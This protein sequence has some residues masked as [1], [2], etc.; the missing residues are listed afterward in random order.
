[1][2]GKNKGLRVNTLVMW[3]AMLL[4][5]EAGNV[6][7]F[8]GKGWHRDYN[9]WLKEEKGMELMRV[10]VAAGDEDPF[11]AG[12]SILCGDSAGGLPYALIEQKMGYRSMTRCQRKGRWRDTSI[13]SFCDRL[14]LWGEYGFELW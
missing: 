14:G 11:P 8:E 2:S 1:M 12:L 5:M 9:Q 3:L 4:Q 13:I 7:E 6:P 10:E